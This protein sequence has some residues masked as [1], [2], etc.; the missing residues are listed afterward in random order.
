MSRRGRLVSI[1]NYKL[2]NVTLGEGG[3]GKVELATHVITEIPVALKIINK[4]RTDSYTR[5][6]LH[7]EANILGGLRHPC[8]IRLLEILSTDTL[9]CF[10]L[11]YVPSSRTLY[12]VLAE[13]GSLSEGTT[14]KLAAQ[15]C[16]A[17][18]YLH[19]KRVLHR[20]LKLDNILVNQEETECYL[21][22]FGLSSF[23]YRGKLMKT[24]CGS[25]EYAAPELFSRD[26]HYGP[27]VDIWSL[28]IVLYGMLMGN[29]GDSL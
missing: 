8:I 5:K 22:D 21:I 26:A 15:L 2:E 13:R 4:E 23:W 28:G 18:H 3:F 24:Y 1:G 16:C 25:L 11:E 29:P 6:N 17:L 12:E 7:R 20:D 14:R 9:L 10:A 19:R 27:P